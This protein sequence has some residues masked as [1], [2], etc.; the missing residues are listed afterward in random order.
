MLEMDET[1]VLAM[2]EDSKELA[3]TMVELWAA[4]FEDKLMP[5]VNIK[6]GNLR[7]SIFSD[8]VD[9]L[10]WM[11]GT[12]L[13]YAPY[14]HEGFDSFWLDSPVNIDGDWVYIKQHPGYEGNPFFDDTLE[15]TETQLDNYLEDAIASLGLE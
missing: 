11:F 2:F 6:T 15:E 7:S 8:P 12:D 3:S 5:R 10:N 14:V 1:E 4:D 9:S 13:F